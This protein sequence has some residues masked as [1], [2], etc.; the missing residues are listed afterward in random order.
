MAVHLEV[1]LVPV[2]YKGKNSALVFIR[3]ISERI[4]LKNELE[5]E[6]DKYRGFFEDIPIVVWENDYSKPKKYLEMLK[7]N[8]VSDIIDYLAQNPSEIIKLRSLMKN[9]AVNKA[10]LNF[11][12]SSE[13]GTIKAIF[14][15]SVIKAISF[16][17]GVNTDNIYGHDTRMMDIIEG[18]IFR[19]SQIA[20]GHTFFNYDSSYI[21]ASHKTRFQHITI[22]VAP[23][24]EKDPIQGI[25]HCSGYYRKEACRR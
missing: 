18:E 9:I 6:R 13:Q 17:S 12:E 24:C 16:K 3:D 14:D 2:K 11:Y 8:G 22:S 23:G 4:K 19:F 7:S 10:G 20:E 25:W 21:T 5:A 1:T 15:E